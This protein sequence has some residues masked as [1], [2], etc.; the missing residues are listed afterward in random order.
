MREE[1]A[2]I[3]E[4]GAQGRDVEAVVV[5]EGDGD[6]DVIALPLFSTA[7]SLLTDKEQDGRTC[8]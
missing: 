3:A 8:L 1:E 4:E 7:Q 2:A 6:A 5:D